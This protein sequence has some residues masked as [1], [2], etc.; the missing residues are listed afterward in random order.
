M[1][2]RVERHAIAGSEQDRLEHR[3]GGAFAVGAPNGDDDWRQRKPEP[4][5]QFTN[6]IQAQLDRARVQRLNAGEPV[7]QRLI[8]RSWIQD[9]A[10]VG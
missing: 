9:S 1:R 10:S 4:V 3:A 2:R 6:A 7:G 8:G 5:G